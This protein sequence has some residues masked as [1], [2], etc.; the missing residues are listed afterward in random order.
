MAERAAFLGGQLGAFQWTFPDC[1]EL[2]S[3]RGSLG[4]HPAADEQGHAEGCQRLAAKWPSGSA[5]ATRADAPNRAHLQ[6]LKLPLRPHPSPQV[7]P[8]Q[9]RNWGP[10][11]SCCRKGTAGLARL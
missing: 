6:A 10:Y 4:N 1:S 9:A 5:G 7:G 2:V 3:D 11:R 8:P